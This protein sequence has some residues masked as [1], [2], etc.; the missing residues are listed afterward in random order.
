MTTTT[1]PRPT[2]TRRT[3]RSLRTEQVP[4]T[5]HLVRTDDQR[6]PILRLTEFE[7]L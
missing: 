7:D 6:D 5:I 4:L 2:T 1:A 3:R